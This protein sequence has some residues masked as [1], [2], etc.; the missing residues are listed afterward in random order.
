M[1]GYM[2]NDDGD[3]IFE[4]WDPNND[5]GPFTEGQICTMVGGYQTLMA[6]AEAYFWQRYRAD[7]EWQDHFRHEPDIKITIDGYDVEV[8][9]EAAACGRGCCGTDSHTFS[10]PLSYLWLDQTTI[11]ADMKAKAD[12]KAKAEA[13]AKVKREAEAK[14]R[15]EADE[16]KRLIELVAKY[17]D[18]IKP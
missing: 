10:F 6:K 18:A 7:P 17:P 1:N 11:L 2:T 16:R 5:D 9:G 8:E 3:P 13:D 15:Q 12:A 14:K 4:A